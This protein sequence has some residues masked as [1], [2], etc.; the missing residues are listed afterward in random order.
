MAQCFGMGQAAGTAAALA[1]QSG[2]APRHL[3]VR[4]LQQTLVARGVNLRG[5]LESASAAPA[6]AGQTR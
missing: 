4:R 6:L 5:L 2:V 1:V 3:D